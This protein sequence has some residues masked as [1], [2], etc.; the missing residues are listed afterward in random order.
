MKRKADSG[1]FTLVEVIVSAV[2]ISVLAA[3]IY[4]TVSQ[5]IKLWHYALRDRP[6]WKI[7]IFFDSISTQLRN[8]VDCQAYPLQGSDHTVGFCIPA[9]GQGKT[10]KREIP[11]I[12]GIRYSYDALQRAVLVE[13]KNYQQ[14]LNSKI[15][16][17]PAIPVLSD[18]N[19][20]H[21]EYYEKQ[22]KKKEWPWRTKWDKPC[23]PAA[24]K[25]T[26]S[27][28]KTRPKTMTRYYQMMTT[29][30]CPDAAAA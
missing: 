21:I 26:L 29:E 25:I 19:D 2:I 18:I 12:A 27:Y 1:G 17:A 8:A 15:P 24:V 5:G 10:N 6:E 22:P 7:D 13:K 4:N 9:R 3:V 16:P 14:V 20:F 23:F 11:F 30:S 28:G